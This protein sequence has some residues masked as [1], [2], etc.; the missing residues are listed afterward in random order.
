MKIHLVTPNLTVDERT[1]RFVRDRVLR[2]IDHLSDRIRSAVVYMTDHNGPKG[3]V[4][5]ECV[6]H[7]RLEPSGSIVLRER[8]PSIRQAVSRAAGK[9][10]PALARAVERRCARRGTKG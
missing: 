7:V 6:I 4:D 10:K 1:D 5:T 9:L 2:T 8:A 3:G